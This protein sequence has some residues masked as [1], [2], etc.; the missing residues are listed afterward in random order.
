VPVR[1][2][3]DSDDAWPTARAF[4]QLRIAVEGLRMRLAY[5]EKTVAELAGGRD[6]DGRID[7]MHQLLRGLE[8]AEEKARSGRASVLEQFER[9]AARMDHRLHQLETAAPEN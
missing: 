5:H 8:S 9:I 4:D 3:D 2:N 6:V 1:A 7:E